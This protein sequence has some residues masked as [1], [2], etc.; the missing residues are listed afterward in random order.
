M[1]E[2]R[3]SRG[4]TLTELMVVVVLIGIMAS[5]AMVSMSKGSAEDQVNGFTNQVRT[6]LVIARNRSVVTSSTYLIDVQATSVRLCQIDPTVAPAQSTCPTAINLNC[7]GQQCENSRLYGAGNNAMVF[8]SRQQVDLSGLAPAALPAGHQTVYFFR[9]GT[10]DFRTGATASQHQPTEAGVTLYLQGS[11][12]AAQ[13][14]H[15]KIVVYPAS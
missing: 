11:T 8:G 9:D 15:R 2:R 10:A 14:K 1:S 4:F 13:S 12:A 3:R 6:L 7:N 5:M